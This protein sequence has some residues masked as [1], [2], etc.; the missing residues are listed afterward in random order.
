MD[1][2]RTFVDAGEVIPIPHVAV[3]ARLAMISIIQ[4]VGHSRNFIQLL[5][6]TGDINHEHL[7]RRAG[8]HGF[9]I[10]WESTTFGTSREL[11][12]ERTVVR[13]QA[14]QRRWS[15]DFSFEFATMGRL[16]KSRHNPLTEAVLHEDSPHVYDGIPLDPL[17]C[18]NRHE[19]LA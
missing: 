13:A 16:W 7:P 12:T 1:E 14:Q 11:R 8:P 3:V 10:R 17:L 2:T 4:R 18:A 15:A 5:E 9:N 6:T 19:V